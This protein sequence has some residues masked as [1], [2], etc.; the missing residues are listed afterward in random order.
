MRNTNIHIHTNIINRLC[1]V[2]KWLWVILSIATK[3]YKMSN[4]FAKR[5]C[6]TLNNPQDEDVNR[7]QQNDF[8]YNYAIIGLEQAPTTGTNHLQGFVNFKRNHRFNRI[9]S[10]IG[11]RAHIEK[12]HGTDEQNQTYCSKERILWEFGE[13]QQQGMLTENHHLR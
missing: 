3:E 13:P 6:F 4:D 11:D 8:L 12:A 7:I 2:Q 9:K 10:I 1:F 5:V